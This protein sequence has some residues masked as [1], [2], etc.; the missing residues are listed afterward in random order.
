MSYD[1]D[2]SIFES[3][4]PA[5]LKALQITL[6]LGIYSS[7]FGT[8]LG[9]PIAFLLRNRILKYISLPL[10]DIFRAIPL[11]VFMFLVYY[12]PYEIFGMSPLSSYYS[13]LY[14][15][16]FVQAV[17]TA[18]VIRGALNN[19][20]KDAIKGAQ[21]I[22]MKKSQINRLVIF[23]DILRQI[24]P[25]LIAFYIGNIKLSSLASAI[26]AHELLF[27]AKV[28]SGQKF[29]SLEAWVLVAVIYIIVVLPLS[30]LSRKFEESKWIKM[31][32]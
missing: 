7:L 10:N 2:F 32:Q 4:W 29:R 22:G 26:N 12:F 1:W 28:I 3:S 16:I 21:S 17:F 25:T 31:K 27:T 14:A 30:V 11:L 9:I 18:D 23:P 6:E 15:M 8:L 5:L 20:P 24:L 19:T 13:A